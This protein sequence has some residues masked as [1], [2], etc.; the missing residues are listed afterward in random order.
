MQRIL[1]FFSNPLLA[2]HVYTGLA[3]ITH[4]ELS[5]YADLTPPDKL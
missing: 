1:P 2:F 3:D 5:Q 4:A